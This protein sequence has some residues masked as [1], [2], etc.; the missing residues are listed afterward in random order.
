MSVCACASPLNVEIVETPLAR[1]TGSRVIHF[2]RAW[3][4]LL[5][6]PIKLII[7]GAAS[8]NLNLPIP[9]HDSRA[10]STCILYTD[11]SVLFN[12]NDMQMSPNRLNFI[13]LLCKWNGENSDLMNIKLIQ[14]SI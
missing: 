3:R 14:D 7:V 9:F 1:I 11:N 12:L 6:F 4:Y 10:R 2:F 5:C 8:L 13:Y